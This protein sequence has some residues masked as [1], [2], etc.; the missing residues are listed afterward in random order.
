MQKPLWSEIN[1]KEFEELKRDIY[2]NKD[3]NELKIIINKRTYDLKTVKKF[4]TEVPTR[5]TTK[6][7]AK[8]LYNEL[9]QKD[10][11]ALKRG[12]SNGFEKYNLLNILSN[13][14][15]Y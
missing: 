15:Q 7:E 1:K 8:K 14:A 6:S 10:I 3:S 11:D 5:R 2:N 9:I 12:K 4:W 13:E